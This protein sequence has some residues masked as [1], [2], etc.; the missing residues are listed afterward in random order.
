MLP[1]LFVILAVAARFLI[2]HLHSHPWDF[3][4]SA[5]LLFSA[6]MGHVSNSGFRSR[7]RGADGSFSTFMATRFRGTSM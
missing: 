6:R 1:Y 2:L 7:C 5:S 3:T 4:H